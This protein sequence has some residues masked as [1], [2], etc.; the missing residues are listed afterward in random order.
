MGDW[1]LHHPLD[2]MKFSTKECLLRSINWLKTHPLYW[3]S[4][5]IV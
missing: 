1:W 3:L 4:S 2:R 5:F